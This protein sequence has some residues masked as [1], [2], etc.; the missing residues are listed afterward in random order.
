MIPFVLKVKDK[1]NRMEVNSKLTPRGVCDV[2]GVRKERYEY[3]DNL[4]G[5]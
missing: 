1:G 4:D 2:E 3:N 5:G